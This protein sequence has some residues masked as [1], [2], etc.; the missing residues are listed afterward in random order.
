MICSLV[1]QSFYFIL[2]FLI[3]PPEVELPDADNIGGW[4]HLWCYNA[5]LVK[6]TNVFVGGCCISLRLRSFSLLSEY[7]WLAIAGPL[8][9]WAGDKER[10][11][12]QHV[13]KLQRYCFCCSVVDTNNIDYVYE[14]KVALGKLIRTL[15][16]IQPDVLSSLLPV[17]GNRVSRTAKDNVYYS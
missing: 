17:I 15:K 14:R 9:G 4:H 1:R 5:H 10:G 11:E 2:F 3:S 8:V 6:F 12:S 13:A 16:T 7:R